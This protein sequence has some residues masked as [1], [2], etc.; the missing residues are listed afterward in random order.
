MISLQKFFSP[1]D[2]QCLSGIIQV[3][4][5]VYFLSCFSWK[6][7]TFGGRVVRKGEEL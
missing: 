5:V 3:I 2:I 1:P 7:N 6:D 4:E